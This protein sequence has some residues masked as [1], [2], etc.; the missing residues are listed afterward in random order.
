MI[1]LS[2]GSTQ[3]FDRLVRTVDQWAAGAGRDDVF[4]QIGDGQYEPQTFG[5]ANYVTP[6]R[7]NELVRA[8]E[9]VIS[10]AGSGSIIG[11]LTARK[12][13]VVLPRRS[14]LKEHW[15][16][17]QVTAALALSDRVGLHV[18]MDEPQLLRVLSGIAESGAP[19]MEATSRF[20]EEPLIARIREFVDLT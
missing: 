10:H 8:S 20:A 13:I 14:S 3:P 11:A 16:D 7:W 12:P 9:F 17:N 19:A 15:N 2:V 4:G 6:T 1:F 5:W 18:A